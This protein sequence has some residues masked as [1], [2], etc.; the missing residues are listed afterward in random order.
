MDRQA[1]PTEYGIW[2]G[3]KSR[4]RLKTNHAYARYGGRGIDVCDEWFDSYLEFLR[5][6]GPRPSLKHSVDR[7]DNHKGYSKENCRW[8]TRKEQGRNKC[9]NRILTHNGKTQPLSVWVE[10]TGLTDGTIDSRIRRGWT[11]DEALTVKSNLVGASRSV[12]I[13]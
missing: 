5:D 10:E 2:Q 8:A 1:I 9:N 3:I 4:C 7:I 13:E 12:D 6:M 11:V